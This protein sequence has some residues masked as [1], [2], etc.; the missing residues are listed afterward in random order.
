MSDGL[1][2]DFVTALAS[3]DAG[4]ITGVE[5]RDKRRRSSRNGCGPNKRAL[6]VGKGL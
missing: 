6:E 4:T 5:A 2:T 3:Q 1:W